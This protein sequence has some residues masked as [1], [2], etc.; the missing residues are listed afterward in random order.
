[1]ITGIDLN[2]SAIKSIRNSIITECMIRG[3]DEFTRNSCIMLLDKLEFNYSHDKS[4]CFD[5]LL[6]YY[7]TPIRN[8]LRDYPIVIEVK[9]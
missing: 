9:G 1:M 6:D 7:T 2:M 5:E 4:V 3:V 8:M